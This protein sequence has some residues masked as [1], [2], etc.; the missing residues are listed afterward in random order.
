MRLRHAFA[1]V[2]GA[3][4]SDDDGSERQAI[5][6]QCKSGERLILRHQP[7]N[8]CSECAIQVL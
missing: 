5:V 7:D 8:E 2:A 4:F 6:R 1:K 3:T